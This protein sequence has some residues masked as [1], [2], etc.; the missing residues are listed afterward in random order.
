MYVYH[1][2]Q[3]HIC[4]IIAVILL[5]IHT[6][7]HVYSIAQLVERLTEKPGAVLMQVQVPGVAR[8][9]SPRVNF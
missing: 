4:D 6:Q 5:I 2:I 9:F 3:C 1:I 8:D 7:T